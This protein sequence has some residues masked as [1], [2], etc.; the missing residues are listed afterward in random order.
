M[1]LFWCYILGKLIKY[2]PRVVHACDLDTLPPVYLYKTLFRRK[3]VF[4]VCDRYAMSKIPRQ[5]RILYTLVNRLEEFYASRVD[6]LIYVSNRLEQTF[7]RKPKR[8]VTITNCAEEYF[9]DNGGNENMKIGLKEKPSD[10]LSSKSSNSNNLKLIYTGN[11]IRG[12]GIEKIAEAIRGMNNVS[13]L[14]A[15]K[16]IDYYRKFL[17]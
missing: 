7:Q 13:L 1:P 15:G 14:L 4:D 3:V 10:D 12:R 9:S 16:V 8:S 6:C 17:V 5:R 11:I 2:R